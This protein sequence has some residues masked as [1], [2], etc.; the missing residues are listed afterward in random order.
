MPMQ[1]PTSTS[2]YPVAN[3]FSIAA[4][5]RWWMVQVFDGGLP[6]ATVIDVPPNGGAS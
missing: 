3:R 1:S 6:H 4:A 5:D 2:V